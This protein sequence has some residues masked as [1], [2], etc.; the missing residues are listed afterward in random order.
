MSYYVVGALIVSALVGA[1]AARQQ[2]KTNRAIA[3]NNQAIAE[4]RASDAESRGEKQAQEAQR[5]A[6]LVASAQRAAFAAKGVDVGEGTPQEII[7]QT[8]FFGQLDASTARSNARKEAWGYRTQGINYGN[9]ASANDPN[10]AFTTSLLTSAP[11][12]AGSW[13]RSRG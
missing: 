5:K 3:R 8:D 9:T 12:V 13:Y 10:S 2:A 4:A 1:N 7:D 11:A 6:R